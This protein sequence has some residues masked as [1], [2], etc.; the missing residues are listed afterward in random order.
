[1]NLPFPNSKAVWKSAVVGGALCLIL[2]LLVAANIWRDPSPWEDPFFFSGRFDAQAGIVGTYIQAAQGTRVDCL[3]WPGLPGLARGALLLKTLKLDTSQQFAEPAG[4]LPFYSLLAKA[5]AWSNTLAVL[6][7]LI[8]V[9][10][11]FWFVGGIGQ[12]R[13]TA[14]AAAVYLAVSQMCSTQIGWARTE[15]WSL[16]FLALAMLVMLPEIKRWLWC[17]QP[18]VLLC[19]L[20]G[21]RVV[22]FGFLASSAVLDKV[23]V[24]PAAVCLSVFYLWVSRVNS[25]APPVSTRNPK[26]DIAWCLIPLLLCPWWALS[27]PSKEFWTTVSMYDAS[28][29][30]LLGPMKWYLFASGLV[31]L[32]AL[33]ALFF[34]S[35]RLLRDCSARPEQVAP[36]ALAFAQLASGGLLSLYFWVAVIAPSFSYFRST[37]SHVLTML[38]ASFLGASPYAQAQSGLLAAT[39]YFWESG[40][41]LGRPNLFDVWSAIGFPVPALKWVNPASISSLFAVAAVALII[42]NWPATPRIRRFMTLALLFFAIMVFSDFLASTRGALGLD[43]R[44]YI[45][46]GW[47]GIV[48]IALFCSGALPAVKAPRAHLAAQIVFSAFSVCL[49]VFGLLVGTPSASQQALFGRQIHVGSLTAPNL[50]RKA[51][52]APDSSDWRVL[53][54]WS[55]VDAEEAFLKLTASDPGTASKFGHSREM[56][57]GL[58]VTCL[59]VGAPDRLQVKIPVEAIPQASGQCTL[60]L[61]GYLQC[62]VAERI[63]SI[64]LLVENRYTGKVTQ[65]RWAV[66]SS[67]WGPGKDPVEYAVAVPFLPSN[68]HAFVLIDWAPIAKGEKMTIQ[69]LSTGVMPRSFGIASSRGAPLFLEPQSEMP[70]SK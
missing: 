37:V 59:K 67:A 18:R 2:T 45:Y 36:I 30:E 25:A 12:S 51:G 20:A 39:S 9:L 15:A 46:S 42:S 32:A 8:L 38:A 50:F 23:L 27:F 3:V 64:G 65:Y 57:D 53:M 7:M 22:L 34:L 31:L 66:V 19:R 56:N 17:V 11:T 1:M 16:A 49:V 10:A 68:E 40:A 21:L 5:S 61:S 60:A 41:V 43:F 13:L 14:F 35:S 54:E 28:S 55:R 6:G 52:I 58:S 24:A 26:G 4:K 48:G 70:N 44:Y 62:S 47:F 63:P 69:N 33:P 29:A